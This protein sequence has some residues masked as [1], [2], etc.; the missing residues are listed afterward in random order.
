MRQSVGSVRILLGALNDA[1]GR[2]LSDAGASI[3]P[4]HLLAF[5]LS[6]MAEAVVSF[7]KRL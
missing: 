1:F 3:Q 2:V 4:R 5:Y 6:Q 7:F